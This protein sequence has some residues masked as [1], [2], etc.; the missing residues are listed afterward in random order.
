LE[1]HEQPHPRAVLG[2]R[3]GDVLALEVDRPLADLE[4]GMAHDHVRERRL[5]G[6]VGSHERVDLALRDVEVEAL[7]DVLVLG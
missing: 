7:E 2:R 6:P 3:L 1:R 5:A 4:A